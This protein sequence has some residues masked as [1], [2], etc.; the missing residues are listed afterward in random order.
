MIVYIQLKLMARTKEYIREEVLEK[1]AGVF[2]G[3]GYEASSMGDLVKRTGLNTFS[4]YRE[5]KNK[6][7]LFR[8]AMEW[9]YDAVLRDMTSELRSQPGFDSLV[10]FLNKFPEILSSKNFRGC[11]FMNSLV[12]KKQLGKRI[13][14]RVRVFCDELIVL[15][16]RNI[17]E[18]QC[19]R[20]IADDQNPERLA[21]V[22]LVFIQGLMLYGRLQKDRA[23]VQSLVDSLIQ[24]FIVKD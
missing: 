9:Y 2:W 8:A 11:M 7:G 18:A 21:E 6:Q 22:L 20:K 14:D 15:F 5:F 16:R 23:T 13:N 3:N 24:S 1:A 12:E 10:I 19:E 17:S 4:M